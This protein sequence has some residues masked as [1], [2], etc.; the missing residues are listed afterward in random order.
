VRW[1][2]SPKRHTAFC[3]GPDFLHVHNVCNV[4]H[5]QDSYST[6]ISSAACA[7]AAAA[8]AAAAAIFTASS[9]TANA[10]AVDQKSRFSVSYHTKSKH[11][12]TKGQLRF[13]FHMTTR[14]MAVY[15]RPNRRDRSISRMRPCHVFNST[16][17]DLSPEL[18]IFWSIWSELE[19]VPS[20]VL[21]SFLT[22][23][24]PQWP[25]LSFSPQ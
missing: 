20:C 25:R 9:R 2:Q 4:N 19:T 15:T 22:Q 24:G 12:S 1:A 11:E 23:M 6:A 16:F 18:L 3:P 5:Y 14:E 13:Q 7:A 8:F 21:R 10:T 17:G